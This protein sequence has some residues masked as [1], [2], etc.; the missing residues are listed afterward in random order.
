M[1]N[2]VLQLIAQRNLKAIKVSLF[3]RYIDINTGKAETKVINKYTK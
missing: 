2:T 3:V 1:Y